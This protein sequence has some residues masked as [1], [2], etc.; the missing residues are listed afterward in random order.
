MD[1]QPRPARTE[2]R[3]WA[4]WTAA[5]V[6]VILVFSLLASLVHTGFGTVTVR[7]IQYMTGEGGLQRALLYIP[8]SA[9]PQSPA[10]AIVACHGYNNTA[11]VQ[12]INSI[13][14][15]RRGYVVI[16]IDAYR[17]GLS[18]ETDPAMPSAQG[19][20]TYSA[21]QYLGTL[22]YVLPRPQYRRL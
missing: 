12:D 16:S 6:A 20:G 14:L 21:L 19:G 1:K 9:T 22:P 11:E 5:L 2:T 10:P 7:D 4:V 8:D 3:K 18:S 15:S 17:H 13:E